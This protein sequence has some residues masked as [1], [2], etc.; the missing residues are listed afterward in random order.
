MSSLIWLAQAGE[1]TIANTVALCSNCHRKMHV[2]NHKADK[3]KLT[4]RAASRAAH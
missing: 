3:A 4:T 2:L 1:D